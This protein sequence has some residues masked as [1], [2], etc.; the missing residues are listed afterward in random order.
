MNLDYFIKLKFPTYDLTELERQELLGLDKKPEIVEETLYLDC[1]E[2]RYFR[3]SPTESII[4]L[5]A[6]TELTEKEGLEIVVLD[7]QEEIISQLNEIKINTKN[8]A[9]TG[10]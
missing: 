6:P 8:N 5:Y 2:I 9:L 3:F 7:S 4:G 1:R 10:I